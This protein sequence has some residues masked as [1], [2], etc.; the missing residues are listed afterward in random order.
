[1]TTQ[2]QSTIH[3]EQGKLCYQNKKFQEAIVHF[4]EAIRLKPDTNSSLAR[5]YNARGVVY[6]Y[7]GEFKRVIKDCAKALELDPDNAN[8]HNCRGNAWFSLG[9]FDKVLTSSHAL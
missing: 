9:K 7:L 1:M 6:F 5:C 2:S 4:T 3:Y 8:Y